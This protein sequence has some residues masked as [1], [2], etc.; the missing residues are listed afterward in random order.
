MEK[1]A[2]LIFF[3]DDVTPERVAAWIAK[4]K[5]AGHVEGA[6]VGTYDPNIGE[7]VWYVP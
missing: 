6:T 1:T 2:A 7:P 5:E 4:L 3:S